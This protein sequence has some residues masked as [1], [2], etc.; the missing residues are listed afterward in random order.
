MGATG[1]HHESKAVIEA[2]PIYA[3]S[4]TGPSIGVKLS[5]KVSDSISNFDRY[6][7]SKPLPA[8]QNFPKVTPITKATNSQTSIIN[9]E[10]IA[11]PPLFS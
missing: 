5:T 11:S 4:S 8:A 9:I 6:R 1:S 3:D 2:I 10:F 7:A